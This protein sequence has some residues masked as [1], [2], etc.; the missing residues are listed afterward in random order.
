MR[1]R[2]LHY[3]QIPER[4]G[5]WLGGLTWSANGE[6]VEAVDGSTGAF[7]AQPGRVR[8]SD[9]PFGTGIDV[10]ISPSFTKGGG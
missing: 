3:L 4:Y 6:A 10:P 1:N 9:A 5:R 2:A 8:Q 7:A